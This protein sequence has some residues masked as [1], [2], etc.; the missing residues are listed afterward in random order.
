MAYTKTYTFKYTSSA[1][2]RYILEFH[3]QGSNASSWANEQGVLGAENCQIDWGSENSKMF[4]PL[5][6]S[7]MTIDFMVTDQKAALYLKNLRTDRQERDVYVY[8]Y[9]TGTTGIKKAGESPIFAGYLLMDLA[10]DPDIP[11]PFPM[12]LRAIDGL[13]SLKYYDFIPLTEDQRADHL[14]TYG[15]T[16]KPGNNNSFNTFYPFR[17]WIS[18][19]LQ[20][21][22]YAT[23]SKGCETDAEFQT[24]VN[25]YNSN[26]P[27]TTGDPLNWTR[28]LA[29]QFY[30]A[31]GDT[32]NIKYKPLTCYDALQFI[33]KTWG[34]RCFA[35]KNTF[36][37]VG[38]NTYT[39]S[40]SGTLASPVNI[41]FHRYTI[42]GSTA[43]PATGDAL[44][45][46]WGRYNIP[47][48][49]TANNKKIAGSQYGILPA[50]KRVSVDFL[51]ISNINYFQGFPKIPQPYPV[52]TGAGSMRNEQTI[53]T[54]D[55]DGIN[56]KTFYQEIYLDFQNNSGGD[57]RYEI[58]WH[59][60]AKKVGT[61]TWYQYGYNNWS[62]SN[63]F[64][65]WFTMS[66]IPQTTSVFMRGHLIIPPGSSSFNVITDI[67]NPAWFG[68]SVNSWVEC[69]STVFSAGDWEFKYVTV[70][71]WFSGSQNIAY[72]HGRCDP[73][74]N[75]G[76]SYLRDPDSN[77]ITYTDSTI[78]QGPGASF[79]S[80][81]TNGVIGT[82]ATGTQIVQSGSDTEFE[83]VTD[84]LWGDLPGLG[85][86]RIQV[87]NGTGWVPS[88]FLGT[89]GVDTLTGNNSLAETLCEEIF[90]RQAKNVR[91]F[92]TKINLDAEEIYQIDNSG[93][94]AM[95]PAPFTK[96]AT[97]SHFSSAT[98]PASWIMHT[99]NFDTGA[100]TWG[101]TLYEFETF[102]VATTTTTTG[103]N[104]GNS[105]GVGTNTG[106]GTL[107]D[108]DGGVG[109][110][111]A[112]PTRNNS[113]AIAQLRQNATRPFTVVTASQ[114]L[115][116]EGTLTVTSLTVQ[117]IP[118]A[119]LKTGDIILLM[120]AYQP[121]A[122][123][124]LDETNT[125]EYG[126]VEFEVSSDQSAGDTT[127]SVTSKT[128]Y[129]II[130]KGD[131]VTISQPDLMAQYQNK[132]RG[133]VGG[134]DITANSID[135]GSVSIQ[136]YIDDDTFGTA[137]A[138]SLAT[139]E[140]IKAY[141]DTQ[142]G[143]ADTLQE[144]TD[145]GNTTTNSITFAGGTSTGALTLSSTVDQILILKSTDDGPVYQ[146][147][148]R[149]SDR[150]AYLGFGGSS[151]H[152]NIVNEESSGTI[153]FGTGGSEKMRLTTTGL[154]IGTTSGTSTLEI[155]K[156]TTTGS[157]FKLRRNLSSGSMDSP[158]VN[159]V[160]D[161][162]YADETTLR[163]Q[164]DGSGDI[165]NVFDGT[166]EVF[167]ILDG[168]NVGISNASPSQKLDVNGNINLGN[169]KKITFADSSGSAFTSID[170]TDN[171]LFKIVQA[172]SGEL[173]LSVGFNDNS[174]NKITFFTQGSLEKMRITNDGNLLIG[175]TSDNGQK[176]QVTGNISIGA[177]DKIYLDGGN[178]T[179]IKESSDNVISFYVN[180]VHK[181]Y[182]ESAGIF[183]LANV[184]S[185]STGMFRNY[186]GVWK[187]TTGLTG[188]GFEF[189]NSVDGTAMTL[190][191]TGNAVLSGSLTGTQ[192]FYLRDTGDTVNFF[193]RNES[194]YA[195]ISNSTRTLNII[196]HPTIF[197]N[198]S[199]AETMRIHAN[200]DVS[201][202]TTNSGYKLLVSGTGWGGEGIK[203]ESSS[204]AGAVLTLA[205]TQRTFQLASRG[206]G[207]S[208]RDITDSDTERF[209]I[210]SAGNTNVYGDFKAIDTSENV[211]LYLTAN[212][213]YNSIIY[214][215]DG[216]SSTVGRIQY[217]HANNSLGFYTNA[218][219]KMRL[220]SGGDLAIGRTTASEKVDVQGNII[221]RG[222]NNLTIGS[223]SSGGDF[224]LSSG[225][226][227]YKFANNNG[228]LLTISS[229]G[230]VLIGT[231]TDAGVR[232]YVNGV[233]RAV[234]GGIQA[235]QDYGFTLND[236][237][238]SNRYGLK[239]G[240]AGSV[241][242]SN[243]L[244]L[245]NR[246]F[247][248]ATGGGE[249]AI[250]GNTNTSG[251][252]EVEIAR[253]QP[254][255][256][257]ASGTQK[258]VTLESVLK[259]KEQSTPANPSSGEAVIWL[260]S[261][262]DLKVKI[263]GAE[264]TVTRTLAQYEG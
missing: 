180:D 230:N 259:L 95:Y 92:S 244:M 29:D 134:F 91:K 48:H 242:G 17:Q 89:W 39:A 205:N 105:G 69:P 245:T 218:S 249:V 9:N 184:Y 18:R 47:V 193:I 97:P 88:G 203:I 34:M 73:I 212:N 192:Y 71:E 261:N 132:T 254:R 24:S 201:I 83:E 161:S 258:M 93:S 246:S 84:V 32:G 142:V 143:S 202:G 2:I 156:T 229:D 175:S 8:L 162:Q 262:Y 50:F 131:I 190:S 113:R 187:A 263:T 170:Y 157:G 54:F 6:P 130:S 53:G 224:S 90:K 236:E 138:T 23:T 238:G 241:G 126:N 94:R 1:N 257:A 111:I 25:W 63:M 72:G 226:R 60:E 109:F 5:K 137:S 30:K 46:D 166:T 151:D 76:T 43:T 59:I 49:L 216:D 168:G 179:Y 75:P 177:T 199:F 127:I 220:T 77:F 115:T 107:P 114:G 98:F 27:N 33:C 232:L 256:A 58:R 96:W 52:T 169:N 148:Y 128:I 61:S 207:F 191:S 181:A 146:S 152:F 65:N 66:G 116:S 150:H 253:F 38:I 171:S 117:A 214:F 118:N 11:M 26:M 260:D 100:D 197:Q 121:Q 172:N 250:G 211:R 213:A 251:V 219:E 237:S 208:I 158:L 176:L 155:E 78:L 173:R 231:T 13:A 133:T 163:I 62:P 194:N 200:N 20:Y 35:Y 68:N 189:S 102:N 28:A 21:T 120:C 55:F 42:T 80:P 167:T 204:T 165:I 206:N 223:T 123:T 159:I 215:G 15:Q 239:F 87:Y 144:V 10:D 122:T 85:A 240:A 125:I 41:N 217:V 210:D 247:N 136:S 145:N 79:F 74:P 198:G 233:I 209:K 147:Y 56:D 227:G 243:L 7:T 81:I 182:I 51:N 70:T 64:P 129:Q 235:A 45:L 135:S 16:W 174:N 3:D 86:G 101:L 37:F 110:T 222:T 141:V 188:N 104:G 67:L 154:G 139:S 149:G 164:N 103:T 140:S 19:I 106:T 255:V 44:D 153:T 99:G 119:V 196:G 40:N 264:G 112:N 225:I 234:G 57:I 82:E 22:G 124:T 12:K 183:S 108:S 185:S 252:S 31:E 178:N 221:L 195:T 248:S 36:Y 4:S 14:Y 160:E 186:G 228:D